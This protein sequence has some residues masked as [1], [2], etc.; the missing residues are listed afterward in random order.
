MRYRVNSVLSARNYSHIFQ[1][2]NFVRNGKRLALWSLV[3]VSQQPTQP[4]QPLPAETNTKEPTEE[5]E[6]NQEDST[7]NAQSN[8][9]E[10][11]PIVEEDREESKPETQEGS[12]HGM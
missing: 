10:D 6:E 11:I 12:D 1:R 4:T 9:E 2:G 3:G 5:V 7:E 8:M